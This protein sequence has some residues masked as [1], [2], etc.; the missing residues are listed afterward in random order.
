MSKFYI[1]SCH[2]LWREISFLAARSRH[3]FLPHFLKQGL[4][5]TP[6]ILR[7][8]VQTAIDAADKGE[9]DA[10]LIGYGLCG[11]G[12]EGVRARSKPL[13]LM[14][15]HDC[16]TFLLGSKERYQE[17]FDAYPGTYWFSPGWIETTLMPGKERYEKICNSYR[18]K[19]GEEAAEYLMESEQSWVKQYRR[20][21]YVDWGMGDS[22][23]CQEYTRQCAEWLGWDMDC[24][25]GNPRLMADFLESNWD[26][27]NFLIVQ[28][29]KTIFASHDKSVLRAE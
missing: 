17:Y 9:Y 6:D 23:A 26:E 28:P 1:I 25:A 5:N 27:E 13:V 18:E 29:G 8:E 10:I 19:Y 2:V 3:T 11:K 22:P 15:G 14:R 4:H 7:Q 24:L 21:V 20:A 16:I 12:I